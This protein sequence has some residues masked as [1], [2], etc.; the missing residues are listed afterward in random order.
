MT[1]VGFERQ[2][3]RQSRFSPEINQGEFSSRSRRAANLSRPASIDIAAP[4]KTRTPRHHGTTARK[5]V[6][7][8]A[9]EFKKTHGRHAATDDEG[10]AAAEIRHNQQ[11]Q[12]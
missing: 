6:P 2:S 10:F 4:S 5:C 3:C 9:R 7:P 8:R 12:G 11:P 1:F